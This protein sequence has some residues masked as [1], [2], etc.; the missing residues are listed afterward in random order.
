MKIKKVEIEA[1][2]AYRF[3]D[4]GTFDFTN[5]DD[6]PS[7]FVAIYAPNGF[8]KSSFYDA[9]E[10]AITHNLD[11]F[12]G[13]YNKKNYEQAARSTKEDGVAQKILRNKDVP[14][15]IPTRVTVFTTL[16]VPFEQSLGT[17]RSDSRDIK[18][19]E[20]KNKI[21]AYFRKVVL[22]QDEID[23]FLKE[24]KPQDRYKMFMESF[25]GD[26]EKARQELTILLNDNKAIL[27]NLEKNKNELQEQLSQPVDTSTFIQF[28]K[29]A[30][31]LVAEGENLP[32]I[33]E[34]TIVNAQHEL[35]EKII[36]RS[37]EIKFSLSKKKLL[38]DSISEYILKLPDISLRTSQI[39]EKK[40]RLTQ[41]NKGLVNAN[42]YKI[43]QS[44][45]SK[46]S[47]D[48]KKISQNLQFIE[49]LD[50]LFQDFLSLKSNL[51]SIKK[52]HRELSSNYENEKTLLDN[53]F[54]MRN[55]NDA[56]LSTIDSRCLSIRSKLENSTVIYFNIYNLQGKLSNIDSI[57]TES[58]HK[59]NQYRSRYENEKTELNKISDLAI[60]AKSL[61]SSDLSLIELSPDLLKEVNNLSQELNICVLH[62][63]SIRNTQ[64]SLSAQMGIHE[65]L[66]ALGLDYLSLWPTN[67]CPLCHK[68]HD[69]ESSLR[70]KVTNTD[71][72]SMLSKENAA[73][74]EVSSKRQ[75]ELNSKIESI[76]Q[77]ALEVKMRKLEELS[78][79]INKQG[80]EIYR[81]EQHQTELLAEKKSI[82]NQL[83][84]LQNTVARLAK[85]ELLARLEAELKELEVRKN[86]VIK[87]NLNLS[88]D[89]I[90]K[91]TLIAELSGMISLLNTKIHEV[92]SSPIYLKT[93]SYSKENGLS[94]DFLK[95]HYNDRRQFYVKNIND[96]DFEIDKITGQLKDLQQA[97]I[98][99]EMWLD[100]EK[101]VSEKEAIED[102]IS[103]SEAII[104]SY[105]SSL[106]QH[107]D[108]PKYESLDELKDSLNSSLDSEKSLYNG[109]E[110]R[111]RKYDLL[112]ELLKTAESFVNSIKLQNDINE[113]LGLIEKRKDVDLA[114]TKER[115]LVIE[116]LRSLIKSF[117][118]EELI[119]SIYKRIDPHPSLKKVVFRP[120]FDSSDKPGLNIVVSDE[121]GDMVSPILFFSAAQL[122]ILSLSVF[123]ASALHAKDD[124]GNVIDV[125]MI[126]DP[127]QSM[128]SINIL[129]TIDLLRSITVKFNKQIIISTHDE[130]FFGLLQRKIP[131]EILGAK[132][133]KLEK[134][135]VVV[136]VDDLNYT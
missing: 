30:S 68:P 65:R 55:K 40:S 135:G 42:R 77:K 108:L 5:K 18:I 45:L 87:S 88:K 103:K 64:E 8:G 91:R 17:V 95:E 105:S 79:K 12:A 74:L 112:S 46:I 47:N 66:V 89:I 48:Q 53:L 107:I 2:R 26:W 98:A 21:N 100:V 133:L 134:F 1:F 71:V 41:I 85:D 36:T 75:S 114:L 37:N 34:T 69:S 63:Q 11:R 125:I 113:T 116:E 51:K 20:N 16:P 62:D 29:I 90:N 128:D 22:S 119:N 102:S 13:E 56:D 83:N 81:E 101:I 58:E 123:L 120:D 25:G 70:E 84:E 67:I 52:K 130:N 82:Q 117:F 59:L 9:V 127:I 24:A 124:N 27:L 86:E 60:T 72:I 4:D 97:M 49:E 6:I 76:V 115:D 43:L 94:S 57:Y 61:I 121:K 129:S 15:N 99:D 39:T 44:T 50:G 14:D 93:E 10:W 106:K 31:E 73:K 78:L 92:T 111:V 3:K 110:E 131:S 126:D 23:R 19:G 35:L 7:N 38:R 132:F 109:L 122:N 32:L 104:Q 33:D 118:Y 54:Q 96:F 136:P 28:N 80:N